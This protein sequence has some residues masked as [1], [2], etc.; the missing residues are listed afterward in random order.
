VYGHLGLVD[1]LVQQRSVPQVGIMELPAVDENWPI[2]ACDCR[3][4]RLSLPG[5][6][7][8]VHLCKAIHLNVQELPPI[9]VRI[10]DI[11]LVVPFDVAKFP[12]NWT[13]FDRC[14]CS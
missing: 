7:E 4:K 11:I 12:Q 2:F 13:C 8:P 14:L 5:F 9:E 3:I 1:F 10:T 6:F